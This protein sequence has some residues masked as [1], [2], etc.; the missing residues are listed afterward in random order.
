MDLYACNDV[1]LIT[2]TDRRKNKKI[3]F[4][5]YQQVFL[6]GNLCGLKYTASSF[7]RRCMA[8]PQNYR[9][10]QFHIVT[11]SFWSR[12]FVT[13]FKWVQHSSPFVN[14]SVSQKI[15]CRKVK[16]KEWIELK[17]IQWTSAKWFALDEQ[18]KKSLSSV[19][20][21]WLIFIRCGFLMASC[22]SSRFVESQTFRAK[23]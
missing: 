15:R 3:V 8:I 13:T 20:L 22:F 21:L 16:G 14:G 23:S 4:K 18:I 5:K 19:F 1:L 7:E 9:M 2:K 11:R 10:I 6:A 17:H 12:H